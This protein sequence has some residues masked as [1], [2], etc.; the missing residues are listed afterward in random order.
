VAVRAR[1]ALAG[2]TVGDTAWFGIA[3]APGTT[4]AATM[5][6]ERSR[7][8]DVGLVAVERPDGTVLG[9]V[10]ERQLW[11]VR[12]GALGTTSLASVATPIE[13]Y[14]R[15]N[16]DEPLVRALTRLHPLHPMLT[17]WINERLVGVVTAQAVDRRLDERQGAFAGRAREAGCRGGSA[18]RC[19]MRRPATVSAPK[20]QSAPRTAHRRNPGGREGH[21]RERWTKTGKAPLWGKRGLSTWSRRV[22]DS[23]TGSHRSGTWGIFRIDSVRESMHESES[24]FKQH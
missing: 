19:Q 23:L 18:F 13:R 6:W 8:G 21:R 24:S 1:A 15:A 2:V 16:P 3:R 20:T 9:L 7:M 5:L 11:R 12:D 22:G 17:V 4:D 14:G 10:S